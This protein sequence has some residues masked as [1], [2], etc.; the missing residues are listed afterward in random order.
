[1]PYKSIAD[2]LAHDQEH[3]LEIAKRNK[4]WRDNNRDRVTIYNKKRAAAGA[5]EEYKRAR[6]EKYRKNPE[7]IKASAREWRRKNPDKLRVKQR[8]ATKEQEALREE[9]RRVAREAIKEEATLA[10]E[11]KERSESE[12]LNSADPN[13]RKKAKRTAYQRKWKLANRARLA[14]KAKQW[15]LDN[16]VRI[17]EKNRSTYLAKREVFIANSRKARARKSGA[18]GRHTS[19][20]VDAI[21][22]RQKRRCAII[23]CQELIAKDGVNKYHVDHIIALINGGSN[24]PDNLQ[25]LCKKHNMEKHTTDDIEWANRHG[26]LFVL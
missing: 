7:K 15:H 16:R 24:G 18:A 12:R 9:R 5:T 26:L 11:T 14:E 20:D 10:K 23:G 2:R 13:V 22:N 19:A 25:I 4:Q 6:R 17:L 8:S 3:R 1:M 21:W